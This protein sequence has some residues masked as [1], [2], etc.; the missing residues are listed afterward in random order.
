MRIEQIETALREDVPF[1][2]ATASGE[3]FQVTAKE[4]VIVAD[5]RGAIVLMTDD[6][7][8]HVIPFLTMTSLTYL[9]PKSG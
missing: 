9:R 5:K 1:E 4:K 8:V 6:D 3:K 2:I 7:L